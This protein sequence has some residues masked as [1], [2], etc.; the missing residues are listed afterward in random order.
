M[1]EHELYI[2]EMNNLRHMYNICV[3]LLEFDKANEYRKEKLKKLGIEVIDKKNYNRIKTV[4]KELKKA[5]KDNPTYGSKLDTIASKEIGTNIYNSELH[6]YIVELYGSSYKKYILE[7]LK[8]IKECESKLR[9]KEKNRVKKVSQ[10][11]LTKPQNVVL[12]R[13]IKNHL[14]NSNPYLEVSELNQIKEEFGIEFF[15]SKEGYLSDDAISKLFTIRIINDQLIRHEEVIIKG[16][17]DSIDYIY[18]LSIMDKDTSKY[19]HSFGYRGIEKYETVLNSIKEVKDKN[20]IKEY[21]KLYT[22]INRYYHKLS[23]EQREEFANYLSKSKYHYDKLLTPE[24]FN[25]K[26]NNTSKESSKVYKK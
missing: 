23:K 17:V 25:E 8:R 3:E 14:R 11:K 2:K 16:L 18:E 4:E 9:R 7:C 6:K 26:V 5:K 19:I 22:M 20:Y 10:K 13:I 12:K 1:S 21:T 15:N 24:E